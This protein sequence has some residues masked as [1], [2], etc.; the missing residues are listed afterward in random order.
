MQ[1]TPPPST[2]YA[3]NL[4][5]AVRQRNRLVWGIVGAL[6]VVIILGIVLPKV[7][8]PQPPPP[9]GAER[10]ATSFYAAIKNQAYPTAY[11][12]LADQQQ[13]ELTIFS[14][15]LFARE[16]DAQAG[17]V[18]A[19]QE[20]RYDR[21]TNHPNEAEVQERVTRGGH[22]HYVIVLTM[23]QQSDGTWKI[24]AEDRAI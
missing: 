14:F 23:Q 10:V 4:L 18:T 17:P 8:A 15:T 2:Y 20:V 13:A 6:V 11:G 1:E 9:N 12:M 21:D 7:F 22:T 16:Q 3:A 5:A 24:L 19:F